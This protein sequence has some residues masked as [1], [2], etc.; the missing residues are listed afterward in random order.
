MRSAHEHETRSEFRVRL[1]HRLE[2][3]HPGL[4]RHDQIAQHDIDRD[5]GIDQRACFFALL[6]AI[7][8]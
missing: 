8:S 6:A 1:P 5:A 7:T 4:A 3:L 2:Q